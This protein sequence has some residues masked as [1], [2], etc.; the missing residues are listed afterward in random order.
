MSKILIVNGAQPYE[1]APGQL[2][3]SLVERARDT[4]A[5]MGHEVRMTTVADGYDANSEVEAHVWADTVIMQ[6]PVNWMGVPWIF[7]KYMDEVYTAGM[8][9]RLCTGDGRTADAP[10]ANYGMGGSLNGMTY[11]LSVTFNAP[12]EAFDNPAEPFFAGASV[13]DLLRPIHLNAKFFGMQALPTFAA[14][15]VMKNPE[16]EADFARFDAH[17][18][19]TFVEVEHV[20]A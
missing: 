4:L 5:A 13:D 15:D 2:N 16:I 11:M 8:D 18:K 20:P 12:K 1:F 3:A 6:F 17:L 19:S 9:G 10:K 7:K 14:F